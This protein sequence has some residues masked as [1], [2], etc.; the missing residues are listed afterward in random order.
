MFTIMV[1]SNPE[2]IHNQLTGSVSTI[3]YVKDLAND[4]EI[5]LKN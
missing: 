1:K 3:S 5:P 4:E 2:Y